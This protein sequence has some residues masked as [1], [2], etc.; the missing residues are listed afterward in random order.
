MNNITL[1]GHVSKEP[2]LRRTGTGKAVTTFDIAVK[3]PMVKDKYDFITIVAWEHTAEFIEKYFHKGSGIEISGYLTVRDYTDKAGNKRRSTE[4]IA[5]NAD[6]GKSYGK[7]SDGESNSGAGQAYSAPGNP[8][9]EYPACGS[10]N[11]IDGDDEE[12]PF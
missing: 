7:A 10:F 4:V 11:T 5:Q 3:R 1:T 6:F 8:T 2:E 9:P 12:L